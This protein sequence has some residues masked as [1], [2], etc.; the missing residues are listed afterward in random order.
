MCSLNTCTVYRNLCL[1]PIYLLGSKWFSYWFIWLFK[2]LSIFTIY[3]IYCSSFQCVP[4]LIEW[5]LTWLCSIFVKLSKSIFPFRPHTRV[6]R[7]NDS[8]FMTLEWVA[9]FCGDEHRPRLLGKTEQ[10]CVSSWWTGRLC[11]PLKMNW[12]RVSL[13]LTH[14]FSVLGWPL[15]SPQGPV[16]AA[17]LWDWCCTC[18]ESPSQ[19]GLSLESHRVWPF[20]TQKPFPEYLPSKFSRI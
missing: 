14:L 6:W 20:R 5:E 16:M 12:G 3:H 18:A 8:R 19:G 15:P 17:L 11:E 13:T 10:S 1:L 4:L 7:F 9:A 2:R